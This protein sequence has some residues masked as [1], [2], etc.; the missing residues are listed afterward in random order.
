MKKSAK[1]LALALASIS[2]VSGLSA[3]GEVI[4][5]G[6]PEGRTEVKISLLSGGYGNEWMF[7][8]IDEANESQTEYWFTKI[9]DNK[10]TGAEIAS[11]IQGGIVEA[12][13]YFGDD[14]ILSFPLRYTEWRRPIL[15]RICQTAR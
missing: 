11:R 8:L 7:N 10:Y 15:R 14:G 1:F 5:S 3:C 2:C 13:I 4:G 6:V 12:D 9:G